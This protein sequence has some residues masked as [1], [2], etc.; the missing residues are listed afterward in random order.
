MARTDSESEFDALTV[1]DKDTFLKNRG[2]KS[3]YAT[4]DAPAGTYWFRFGKTY[5]EVVKQDEKN[6][7][8]KST[9]RKVPVRRI[10]M[11]ATIVADAGSQVSPGDLERWAGSSGF[12]QYQLPVGDEDAIKRLY[13]DLETIGIDTR[14]LVLSESDITDPDSQFTLAQALELIEQERPFG[15]LAITEGSNGG[16]YLNYRGRADKGDI[17][18]L[19]GH[20]IDSDET[21]PQE[22]VQS[23]DEVVE[24]APF[25]EEATEEAVEGES[26][27]VYDE[28]KQLWYHADTDTY[29]DDNGVE[30]PQEAPKPVPVVKAPPKI[31][32]AKT[33]SPSAVK[34]AAAKANTRPA[35]PAARG[36]VAPPKRTLGKK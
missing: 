34:P 30:V 23:T 20:P 16:K 4:I 25:T 33:N 32:P 26:D 2:S 35:G 29:Y 13:G 19:I 6:S 27:L 28:A 8:G 11:Q 14:C 17:E 1:R 12:F 18:N 36:S 22:E 10:R 31:G 7:E 3:P 9:G 24:E 21:T 5:R 15:K